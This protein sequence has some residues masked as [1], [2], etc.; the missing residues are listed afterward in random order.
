MQ[1]L[2]VRGKSVPG[3]TSQWGYHFATGFFLFSRDSVEYTESNANYGKTPLSRIGVKYFCVA[4]FE[5]KP[6]LSLQLGKLKVRFQS[7]YQ[8]SV[9]ETTKNILNASV[10]CLEGNTS[11]SLKSMNGIF[12]IACIQISITTVNKKRLCFIMLLK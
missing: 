7:N 4:S 1:D 6:N 2:K 12:L 9:T 10:L 11:A 3:F 8:N 5:H